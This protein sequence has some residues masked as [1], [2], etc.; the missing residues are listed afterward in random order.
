MLRTTHHYVSIPAEYPDSVQV[1]FHVQWNIEG[2]SF[3]ISD[4]VIDMAEPDVYTREQLHD[5]IVDH[6]DVHNINPFGD[7]DEKIGD[8]D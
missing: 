2:K 8:A 6:I 1:E 3:N 7:A 4:V 5:I